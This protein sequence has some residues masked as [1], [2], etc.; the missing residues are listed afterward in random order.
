MNMDCNSKY[1]LWK[2]QSAMPLEYARELAEMDEK[3]V[4]EAFSADLAFGTAGL[5]GIMG[6]GTN[7]MNIFTV[8]QTCRL[9]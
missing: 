9:L 4:A 6:A 7:R 3:A 8:A 5:R 2:A 1:E